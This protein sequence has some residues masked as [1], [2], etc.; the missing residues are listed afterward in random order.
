MTY[1]VTLFMAGRNLTYMKMRSKTTPPT[2][3]N[4]FPFQRARFVDHTKF[5]RG[6]GWLHRSLC[7]SASSCSSHPLDTYTYLYISVCAVR[8]RVLWR[9]EMFN[10][11]NFMRHSLVFVCGCLL[12]TS[13]GMHI[14]SGQPVNTHT[15]AHTA[16]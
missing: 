10:S 1:I 14:N 2:Y 16:K 9:T 3:S 15:H 4:T 5:D 13:A 8:A 12:R 11:F 7:I 6:G